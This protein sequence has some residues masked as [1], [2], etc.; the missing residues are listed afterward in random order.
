[1]SDPALLLGARVRGRST[2]ASHFG[3]A[4]PVCKQPL[5]FHVVSVS[6]R[7]QG[8]WKVGSAANGERVCF[9]ILMAVP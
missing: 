2:H 6:G 7:R 1:M 9:E 8:I 5:S 4:C 3:P